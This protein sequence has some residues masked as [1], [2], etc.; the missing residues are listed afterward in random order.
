[1]MIP[2]K[3]DPIGR[4]ALSNPEANFEHPMAIAAA[5]GL[6]AEA[7][8]A[9]LDRWT[10]D[11]DQRL[12]AAGEGMLAGAHSPDDAAL[13]NDIALAKRAIERCSRQ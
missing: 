10:T 13:M 2:A 6:T 12:E 8:L 7:K 4:A 9:V 5:R 1:M 3:I 11:I